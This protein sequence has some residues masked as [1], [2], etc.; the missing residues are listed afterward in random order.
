MHLAAP[1]ATPT[2]YRNLI[3]TFGQW[4]VRRR[5]IDRYKTVLPKLTECFVSGSVPVIA[6]TTFD[7]ILTT[8]S[9]CLCSG[10]SPTLSMRTRPRQREQHIGGAWFRVRLVRHEL[11]SGFSGRF[12]IAIPFLETNCSN[13][14]YFVPRTGLES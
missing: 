8:T 10:L 3:N 2:R 4:H 14:R 9:N 7:L 12:R 1:R 13:F 11:C 5:I 6:Q